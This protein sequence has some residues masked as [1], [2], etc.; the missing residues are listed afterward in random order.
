MIWSFEY[1]LNGGD[2]EYMVN[3]E[4]DKAIKAQKRAERGYKLFGKW[5]GSLW[6]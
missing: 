6:I 3:G 4:I 1:L 2:F 5:F